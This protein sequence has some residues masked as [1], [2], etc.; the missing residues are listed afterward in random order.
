MPVTRG[1]KEK[2]SRPPAR[3]QRN[4][5]K[6]V[7]SGPASKAPRSK[8]SRSTRKGGR[9]ISSQEN[10]EV[11]VTPVTNADEVE[12]GE[13]LTNV[14]VA[15]LQ[16]M[17]SELWLRMLMHSPIAQIEAIT[18]ELTSTRKAR[19][20]ALASL[21]KATGKRGDDI[22]VIEKPPGEAGDKTKGF[23]LIEAMGLDGSDSDREQYK[24]MLV[25]FPSTRCHHDSDA[26]T[27]C[28]CDYHRLPYRCPYFV[29]A[30]FTNSTSCH[31]LT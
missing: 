18:A 14:D 9:G 26:V 21:S 5:D 16:G 19:D 12:R 23:V 4:G 28:P 30:P 25:S 24:A 8:P 6:N 1:T 10:A 15:T 13:P 7:T 29:F 31:S 20:E 17:T 2:A 22:V 11:P 3:G 27:L